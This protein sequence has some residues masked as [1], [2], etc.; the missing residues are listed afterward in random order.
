MQ[1]H[2]Y[3]LS[4]LS[5]LKPVNEVMFWWFQAGSPLCP[6]MCR[7]ASMLRFWAAICKLESAMALAFPIS[8]NT[9]NA[10]LHSVP[11][12]IAWKARISLQPC[13][14]P[15]WYTGDKDRIGYTCRLFIFSPWCKDITKIYNIH[16]IN[17]VRVIQIA[18]LLSWMP[19]KSSKIKSTI[20]YIYKKNTII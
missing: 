13:M 14:L 15:T 12:F 5:E 7:T 18:L 8:P 3:N 16:N 19:Y 4:L 20:K 6:P 1:A 2:Q 10:G 17:K 9:A 11:D